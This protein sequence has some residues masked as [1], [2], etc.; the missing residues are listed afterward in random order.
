MVDDENRASA[1]HPD[2]IGSDLVE[3]VDRILATDLAGL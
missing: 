3:V 2:I 1:R